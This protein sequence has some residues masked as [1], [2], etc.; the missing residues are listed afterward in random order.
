MRTLQQIY[1]G[2][3]EDV[4]FPKLV[5][6]EFFARNVLGLDVQPYHLEWIDM[7]RK[8]K[9]VA[10]MAPTGFGKTEILG[11]AY[12][13][14]TAWINRDKEMCIISKTLPQSTKILN[15]IKLTIENNEL[16]RELIPENK[17]INNWC[18]ATSM[19]LA[20]GCKIYCRPYSENIKGIHVD[21]LLGDEIASYD[22]HSIW[23]R[24]VVTRVNAKNGIVAAISTP[25]NISDL[26]QELLNNQE[27]VGKVY[28][29]IVSGKSIWESKFTLER[30][31]KIR[32][33]I[34]VAAFER[35]YLCNAKA[36]VESAIYPPHLLIECFDY[37]TGFA[38]RPNEGF[39]IIGADFAIA[40][41]PRADFDAYIVV[42]K[43]GKMTRILYGE[44]HKGFPIAAKVQRL[45]ELFQMFRR[46]MDD[47]DATEA[48]TIK[49]V[50]DP[51]NVGQAVYEELRLKG[52][53]VETANFDTISRNAMLINLRQMIE[54]KEI[55]I[56]RY[57]EDPSCMTFTDVLIRELISM[58][59][60]KTKSNIITYQ[61][62]GT[63]DDTVMA[64]AMACK[65]ILQQKEFLDFFAT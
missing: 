30:L 61:S 19:D 39:T 27:Y 48:S 5:D 50:I 14:W 52:L 22:D 31:E 12:C 23:Y 59:E 15:E 2:L 34:G 42:N 46:S 33:E 25:E 21:Y 44:V 40:D 36:A 60:T 13:L 53:P 16:L 47:D 37:Q 29:A 51:S 58:M 56:P 62:K 11:R 41:G 6:Y 49:F 4:F 9:R 55:T 17:P 35:E 7:I 8:N 1:R 65:G 63:H 57:S 18:S 38:Q 10:I 64:L 54:N 28:S 3:T 32:S 20:T 24:F 43:F 45:V 26:M